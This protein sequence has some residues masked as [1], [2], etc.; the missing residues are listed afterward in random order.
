MDK[1]AVQA[2]AEYNGDTKTVRHGGQNGKPFWNMH[3]SQFTF[4]PAFEFPKFNFVKYYTFTATDCKGN[5]HSFTDKKPTAPLTPIWKDI[6]TGLVELEVVATHKNEKDTFKVGQRTFFKCDPFPGRE[7]L[8]KRACSYKECAIKA[9]RYA[10]ENEATQYWLK[11]GKPDP[12]YYHNVYPAKTISSIVKAMIAYAEIEPEMKDKALQLAKNAADYLISITYPDDYALAGIPPTYCFDGLDKKIVDETAPAAD[13]RREQCMMIYPAVAGGMFLLL[14][15]ATGD[16][17]YFDAATRIAE[18]YKANVLENGSWHL[19]VNVKTG[20]V[21]GHNCCMTYDILGFLT[22]YGKRTGEACWKKLEKGYFDYLYKN[23]WEP[24]NWEGQFEDI[25]LSGGLVNLTHF[26]A[27]NLISYIVNNHADDPEMVK[28]AEQLMRYVE[29]QF[30]V[31]GEFAP[32]RAFW[33]NDAKWFSPA[34]LEQYYWHLPIDS[35]TA[36]IAS[37]FMDLYSITKDELMLEKAKALCD[38]ITRMQNKDSGVIPTH[39]IKEDCAENLEN[40]WI[41]CH[42]YSA[43][44]LMKLA[45][46]TGEM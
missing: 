15:A 40:F 37:T 20:E 8:P 39:W 1:F 18:Y 4:V 28:E 34:G 10:F 16:K 25:A 2:L 7:A 3:S 30:V 5:K 44:A 26:L 29:D 42:I 17:K 41:N 13:G 32:W 33:E 31:W 23:C 9:F 35:S 6:P 14:E 45:K 22:A 36:Y 21:E 38:S 19:L 11:Y 24:Y 27:D 12:T 46:I 43:N